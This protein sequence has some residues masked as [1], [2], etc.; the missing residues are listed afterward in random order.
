MIKSSIFCLKERKYGFC[1]P[2]MCV[3]ACFSCVYSDPLW[4]PAP[5][6][7][8]N[9]DTKLQSFF[10]HYGVMAYHH[11]S[12]YIKLRN[13]DI[14]CSALMI[15]SHFVSDDIHFPR[16]WFDFQAFLLLAVKYKSFTLYPFRSI[17]GVSFIFYFSSKNSDFI[18]KPIDFF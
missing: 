2:N 8:C 16:K 3:T 11:A 12:A 15:F 7:D 5:K 6:N 4:T 1:V 17:Y 14:Q 10:I 13:D 9:F 18:V